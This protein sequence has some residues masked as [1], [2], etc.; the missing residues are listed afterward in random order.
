[1]ENSYKLLVYIKIFSVYKNIMCSS[2]PHCRSELDLYERDIVDM[3]SRCAGRF[4]NTTRNSLQMRLR[5][6]DTITQ[7]LIGQ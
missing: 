6:L 4:M 5:I 7:K 1:L 2:Y 3:A